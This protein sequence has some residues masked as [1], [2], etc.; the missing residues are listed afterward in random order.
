[1][2]ADGLTSNGLA[3]VNPPFTLAG[4]AERILPTLVRLMERAPGAGAFR[5]IA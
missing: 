4:E 1:M 2:S 5:M 3:L